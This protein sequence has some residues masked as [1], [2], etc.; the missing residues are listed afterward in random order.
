LPKH[1]G[2]SSDGCKECDCDPTGS[3]DLQCDLVNGQC[4]CRDKVEGRRCDR[5][6]ENTRSKDTGGY[7]EKICEPCDDCYNLV[8]DAANDHR[9]NLATLDKLL[10]QIAEN[11]EPVG[12]DFEYQLRQLQVR[13]SATLAD[14]R[15]SSQNEDGGTLRDRLEDLR[16]KLQ[17]VINLV[18]SSNGQIEEAKTKSTEA[19][20]NV[21][22]AKDIINTARDSL[23]VIS[24][25]LYTYL[26]L[27]TVWF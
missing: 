18:V 16:L 19:K 2:F 5:C 14:A 26:V 10:E 24:N 17:D 3:T 13:V 1:Y 15:I 12:E 25:I 20:T 6:M 21:D 27:V 9:T 4:P 7:G 8:S 11:P 23:K 22:T